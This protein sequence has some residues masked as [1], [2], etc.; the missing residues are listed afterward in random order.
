MKEQVGQ[1]AFRFFLVSYD[2]NTHMDFDLDLAKKKT[3]SNP[4]YYIQYAHA[5]ISGI[6]NSAGE[7]MGEGLN[8]DLAVLDKEEERD[9]MKAIFGFSY[10]LFV[11]AKQLDPYPLTVYLQSLAS[12]FHRFYDRHKV[13][14]DDE[15]RTIAR[16]FLIRAVK[17]IL[18][19]G[20]HILGVSAPERM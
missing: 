18:A 11:C 16:L 6:L 7:K 15:S 8:V 19:Q 2:P 1:D 14:S 10:C 5:R 17:I 13:L 12:Y 3:E 20:L 4:V 9:L